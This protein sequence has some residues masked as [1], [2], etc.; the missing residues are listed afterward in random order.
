MSDL[1]FRI[2]IEKLLVDEEY[3]SRY[4]WMNNATGNAIIVEELAK[5]IKK[6][7]LIWKLFFLIK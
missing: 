1:N 5:K 4:D 6:H 2:E 7:P 3:W